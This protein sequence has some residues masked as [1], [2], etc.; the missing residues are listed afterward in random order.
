VGETLRKEEEPKSAK[1]LLAER[2]AELDKEAKE[3]GAL[4]SMCMVCLKVLGSKPAVGG[5]GG[6][7]HS[8]CSD[9]FKKE[10]DKLEQ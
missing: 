2:T 1:E 10:M 6:V 4:I 5:K 3:K 9:C 8:Y 7:S